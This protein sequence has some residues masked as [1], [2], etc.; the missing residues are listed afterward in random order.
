MKETGV[1]VSLLLANMAYSVPDH[2]RPPD[3]KLH[4]AQTLE[5]RAHH[6]ALG[7]SAS[8]SVRSRC[9][10]NAD[11]ANTVFMI[12]RTLQEEEGPRIREQSEVACLRVVGCEQRCGADVSA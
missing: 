1:G 6:N 8:R 3:E 4:R 12:I 7:F 5:F 2:L 9:S 10:R 11:F